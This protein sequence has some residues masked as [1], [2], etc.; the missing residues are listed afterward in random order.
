MTRARHAPAIV[1]AS[2]LVLIPVLAAVTAGAAGCLDTRA[3]FCAEGL[4]CPT[5]LV[6]DDHHGICVLPDQLTACEDRADGRPCSFPGAPAGTYLCDHGVCLPGD[7]CGNRTLDPGEQCDHDALGG[8]TCVDFGYSRP[9]GLA[10][11]ADCRLDS[12]GCAPT[13]GDGVHEPYEDCD[14]GNLQRGDGCDAD[15]GLET[16]VVFVHWNADATAVDG[17]HWWSAYPTVSQ[18]LRD[19]RVI[20]ASVPNPDVPDPNPDDPDGPDPNPDP[21]PDDPDDATGACEIWV[22]AGTYHVHQGSREDS[23]TLPANARLFGGFAGDEYLRPQRDPA[24]LPTVLHGGKASDPQARV[25]HVIVGGPDALL[26]GFTITAGSAAT[27]DG[28]ETAQALGG[29][30]LVPAHAT[31]MVVRSCVFTGNT[32]IHGGAVAN[33]A[34]AP[35]LR[36]EDCVFEDN[37]ATHPNETQA[38]QS[39]GGALVNQGLGVLEIQRSRFTENLAGKGGAV[40]HEGTGTLHLQGCRFEKNAASYLGGAFYTASLAH[41]HDC[42]F[43]ANRGFTGG[44]ALNVTG[45]DATRYTGCVFRQNQATTYGAGVANYGCAV[46]FEHCR[47]EENSPAQLGGAMFNRSSEP[48]IRACVFSGNSGDLGGAVFSD[49]T[50]TVEIINTIFDDNWALTH[51]GTLFADHD[52]HL[53]IIHCT[54]IRGLAG[55]SGS[56]LY[57]STDAA[58]DLANSVL[59]LNAHPMFDAHGGGVDARYS[60]ITRNY[61]GVGILDATPIFEDLQAGDLRLAAGSPGI[62]AADGDLAPP[63]D[64]DGLPR[65]DDPSTPNTGIGIPAYAD[66]GAHEHQAPTCP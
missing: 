11:R 36:I 47:F 44:G 26:D 61:P 43:V 51:G 19:P 31:G 65:C 45:A 34:P 59:A 9:E 20:A 24:A 32:A 39:H 5:H 56:V 35:G 3:G 29:G 28:S 17:R 1:F 54:I 46:E 7:D 12:S 52:A 66:M 27:T 4:V 55:G 57:L 62:D 42:E 30:L 25:Y 63:H 8:A 21:N 37:Q 13:C 40:S 33:L 16:C 53:T 60:L 14:D 41:L 50:S 49:M 48:S 10:C 18:A 6:C 58:V 15:C 22:A 38:S 2:G 64:M 23:L